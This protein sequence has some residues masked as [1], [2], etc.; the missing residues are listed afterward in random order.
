MHPN[1]PY[2]RPLTNETFREVLAHIRSTE[3]SLTLRVGDFIELI[4]ATGIRPTE[5][6]SMRWE[7]LSRPED[8]L[9]VS[10][11]GSSISHSLTVKWDAVR[12][13][14]QLQSQ[15]DGKNPS[16]KIFPHGIRK[17]ANTAIAA[18]CARLRI[19]KFTCSDVR[20]LQSATPANPPP[21]R[22]Y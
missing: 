6:T 9:L 20:Q 18:A 15:A 3:E 16:E 11:R 4:A 19:E 12:L 10:R 5:L 7:H 14:Q 21:F 2:L 1:V 17:A 13:I 8:T 22:H